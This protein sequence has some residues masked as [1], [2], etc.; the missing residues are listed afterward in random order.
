MTRAV[1]ALG[2]NLGDRLANLQSAIDL[3]AERG[4]TVTA[5]SC[6]WETEPVPPG[7]PR[8]LNAVIAGETDLSPRDLL[9]V[10]KEVEHLL[11]RRESPRWSPRPADVDILFYDDLV[12]DEPDLQVPHLRIA[13]RGFVLAPLAEVVQGLLPVLGQSAEVLLAVVGT[14]GLERTEW[15][16]TCPGESAGLDPGVVVELLS[17]AN[18]DKPG[19]RGQDAGDA[20]D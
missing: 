4:V 6:V 20:E 7:Q 15:S 13:E 10:A 1:L 12:V 19:P 11:G 17:A 8:Y 18:L 16:L 5:A 14:V 9:R 2:S 3:L